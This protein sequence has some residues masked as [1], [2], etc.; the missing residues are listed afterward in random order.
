LKHRYSSC[1]EQLVLEAAASFCS[2]DRDLSGRR[3]CVNGFD[4]IDPALWHP[5]GDDSEID[6]LSPHEFGCA[7]AGVSDTAELESR[8]VSNQLAQRIT[9]V[10]VIV[11]DDHGVR[12]HPG[13]VN[14]RRA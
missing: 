10:V 1:A 7:C 6:S 3:N 4:R 2:E 8:V 12:R 9:D 13:R 11:R 5:D 14:H